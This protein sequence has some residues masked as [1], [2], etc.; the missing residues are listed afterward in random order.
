MEASRMLY[1]ISGTNVTYM[2]NSLSRG[3][4][5]QHSQRILDVLRISSKL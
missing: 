5:L 4:T 2:T 1:V 3:L